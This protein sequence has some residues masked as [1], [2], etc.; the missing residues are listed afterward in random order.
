[1][2]ILILVIILIVAGGVYYWSSQ[3]SEPL[4]SPQ[5]AGSLSPLLIFNQADYEQALSSNKLIILYFYANWCPLCK[6]ELPYLYGA[7]NELASDQVIGFR[8]HYNDN[9]TGEAEE[10]LAREYGVA[11][12]HTKVFIKNGERILKAPESWDKDRY[13]TEI[14]KFL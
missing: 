7:F 9:E 4:T 13:L 11:Y 8:V 6:E 14:N 1:M 12:Q 2:K 5:L 10:A 3:K